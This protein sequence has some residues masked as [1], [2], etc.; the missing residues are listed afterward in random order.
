M[1]TKI[2]KNQVRSPTAML[3]DE[4][5][6]NADSKR[7]TFVDE[8]GVITGYSADKP[9]FVQLSDGSIEIGT[10]NAELEVQLSHQDDVPD[11]GDI[12]DSV[13]IGDGT[14]TLEINPDGSIKAPLP[15]TRPVKYKTELLVNGGSPD[16]TVDGSVTPV[17]FERT[18][19]TSEIVFLEKLVL[20][21]RDS[22]GSGLGDFGS[23]SALTNGLLIEIQI[24]GIIEMSVVVKTNG[25]LVSAADIIFEIT[26]FQGSSLLVYNFV[27]RQ[28]ISINHNDDDDFIRVTVQ[29]DL[30]GIQALQMAFKRWEEI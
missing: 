9:L 22:G 3:Q 6:D 29:D 2:P 28:P 1:G 20:E 4:H 30:S 18:F 19:I 17:V 16:M 12:A 21:I 5:E 15:S 10:V 8:S 11:T 27:F 23:G 14:D 26:Q 25:E 7:V 24:G 13:Q